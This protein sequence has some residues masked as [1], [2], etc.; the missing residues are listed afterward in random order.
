[1][2]DHAINRR[3][4]SR[5]RRYGM[6]P[7]SFE[8]FAPTSLDEALSM[9]ERYGD[10]GK[11]L[12]GGQS[13]IPLMKLRFA[14]PR[15]VIDINRIDGLDELGERDGQL[16]IGAL[17]RQDRKSTRLNSSHTVISYAVF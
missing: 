14:A 5:R 2:V 9:L 13:L 12:A 3:S 4:A 16:R 17:V 1:M 7:A 8:Y 10:E 11:V 6:Y 15:A